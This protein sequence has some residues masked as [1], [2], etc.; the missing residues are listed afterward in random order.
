MV[1]RT[2]HP[3][4]RAEA[5]EVGTGNVPSLEHHHVRKWMKGPE[6]KKRMG[7]HAPWKLAAKHGD[8]SWRPPTVMG[9]T[10]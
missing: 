7:T 6:G 2:W 9:R 8:G 4:N 3:R 10:P 5:F 1:S